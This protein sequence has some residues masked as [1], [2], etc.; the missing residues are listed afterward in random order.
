D[1]EWFYLH[2][3]GITST[4][5][6][7]DESGAQVGRMVYGAWGETLSSSESM[8]GVL[9]VGFVG[10][11]GVRNDAATGLI[12]MRHRWYDCELGRFISRDPIG[13]IGDTNLYRYTTNPVSQVDPSGL[14]VQTKVAK[15][16]LN[17]L[18]GGA[19][20]IVGTAIA[21]EP[22]PSGEVALVDGARRIRSSLIAL[23]I[24]GTTVAI[25]NAGS[26]PLN[27]PSTYSAN[28]DLKELG[29]LGRQQQNLGKQAS[30]TKEDDDCPKSLYHY[31]SASGMRGIVS[32]LRINASIPVEGKKNAVDGQGVYLTSIGPESG[33]TPG[34][35]SRLMKMTPA[36]WAQFVRYAEIDVTGYHVIPSSTGGGSYFISTGTDGLDVSGRILRVGI[37]PGAKI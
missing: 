18:L 3:D 19:E 27:G 10:G 16:M 13:L 11:L 25:V 1:D 24:I 36:F 2:G 34:Q 32:D 37:T 8:P 12:W 15:E 4:Q 5:L 21:L 22:T 26:T 33:L 28:S 9:D 14:V 17:L 31:S 30:Q 23:G 7:T 29:I 6:V 35:L 20:V